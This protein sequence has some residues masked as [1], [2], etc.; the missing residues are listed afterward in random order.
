MLSLDALAD[1][2]IS[3]GV[4]HQFFFN[5]APL[6]PDAMTL[7]SHVPGG[8]AETGELAFDNAGF[9]VMTRSAKEDPQAAATAASQLDY[10][11]MDP[12][13][14]PAD[15]DGARAIRCNRQTGPPHYLMIDDENRAYYVCSYYLLIARTL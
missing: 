2:L 14:F 1:H 4:N 13:A 7:L 6:R 9:Q 12:N 8:F 10:R 3:L 15:L 5:R 11:I